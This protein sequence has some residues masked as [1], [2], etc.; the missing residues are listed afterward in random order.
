MKAS[1]A[2]TRLVGR[3]TVGKVCI[4]QKEIPPLTFF[5]VT[6]MGYCFQI[7]LQIKVLSLIS[8]TAEEISQLHQKITLS[9]SFPVSAFALF[10][11]RL[12]F[13][14]CTNS[15]L[16]ANHFNIIQRLHI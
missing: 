4:L 9:Y 5:K 16:C 12:C 6:K 8:F 14:L 11:Q 1:I 2:G 10:L 15:L 3:M 13:T 7:Q